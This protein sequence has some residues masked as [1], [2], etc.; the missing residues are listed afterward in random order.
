MLQ[1]A[2][3]ETHGYQTKGVCYADGRRMATWG[4]SLGQTGIEPLQ[5]SRATPRSSIWV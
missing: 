4:G 2:V 3:W 1:D 5:L